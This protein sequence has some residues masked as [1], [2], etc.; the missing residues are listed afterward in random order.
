MEIKIL[1]NLDFSP[2]GMVSFHNRSLTTENRL[3]HLQQGD[4]DGACGPY[5]LMMA[6]LAYGAITRKDAINLWLGKV[7][8]S[9][10]FGKV[11]SKLDAL[12][13]NGTKSIHL[14]KL[15]EA[16][17]AYSQSNKLSNEA[18]MRNLN[19]TKV[20][21][22]GRPLFDQIKERTIFKLIKTKSLKSGATVF[23]YE[24]TSEKSISS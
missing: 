1:P 16:I 23:S 22:R 11:V 24:P 14:K 18:R 5:S 21:V 20:K 15:F 13:R 9:T 12:I 17:K 6:L 2:S 8:S 10:K 7:H 3:I 19:L 4:L